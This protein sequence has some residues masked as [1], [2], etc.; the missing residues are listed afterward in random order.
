MVENEAHLP[1][2]AILEVIGNISSLIENSVGMLTSWFFR[3]DLL[4]I[5]LYI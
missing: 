3:F 2:D 4:V 5:I 1:S